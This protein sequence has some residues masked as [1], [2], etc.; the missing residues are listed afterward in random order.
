[1]ANEDE[2]KERAMHDDTHAPDV[3]SGAYA[4]VRGVAR[5]AWLVVEQNG[6]FYTA[7]AIVVSIVGPYVFAYLRALELRRDANDTAKLRAYADARRKALDKVEEE[8][9]AANDGAANASLSSEEVK[10]K[11]LAEIDARAVRLGVRPKGQGRVLGS[12][13]TVRR[14]Y[15]PLMGSSSTS[16]G[17]YRP[18][19]RQRPGGGG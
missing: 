6:W 4:A 17:G 8:M 5:R 18:T 7:L 14:E 1:M 9:R 15:S 13:P 12:D 2:R 3:R 16:G 10:A 11:K 19:Q